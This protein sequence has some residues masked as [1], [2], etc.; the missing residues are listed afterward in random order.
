MTSH[1][2][3]REELK[4]CGESRRFDA[5]RAP[6]IGQHL[7]GMARRADVC[8]D[9]RGSVEQK[10]VAKNDPERRETREKRL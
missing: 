4:I 1:V 5:E 8:R 6:A 2:A 9:K 10:K 7:I 3:Q